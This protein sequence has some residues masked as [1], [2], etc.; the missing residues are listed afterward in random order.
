MVKVNYVELFHYQEP[1]MLVKVE[2]RKETL[3][4]ES[5]EPAYTPEELKVGQKDPPPK[6]SIPNLWKQ[7]LE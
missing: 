4:E 3:V 2:E 5:Y 1:E 6:K 7:G